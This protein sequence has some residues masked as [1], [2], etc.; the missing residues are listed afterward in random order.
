MH[1]REGVAYAH[2]Q[3]QR[4][5]QAL[6]VRHQNTYFVLV[7]PVCI[8]GVLK[9]RR[10]GPGELPTVRLYG[11]ARTVRARQNRVAQPGTLRIL[12]VKSV[13]VV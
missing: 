10:C 3:A 7:V 2:Q 8:P 12:R 1:L 4:I 5:A 9:V 11:K 6:A 13:G